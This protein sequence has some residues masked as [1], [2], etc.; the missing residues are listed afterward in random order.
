M[1]ISYEYMFSKAM[2]YDSVGQRENA[3]ANLSVSA[4]CAGT[5]ELISPFQRDYMSR[6]F[7]CFHL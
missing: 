4:F 6:F 1:E 7:H 5:A 2:E 3:I